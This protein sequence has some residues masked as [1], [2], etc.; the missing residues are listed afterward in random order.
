[1]LE[2]ARALM[3]GSHGAPQAT[4]AASQGLQ[5]TRDRAQARRGFVVTAVLGV[6]GERIRLPREI[7]DGE[8]DSSQLD[9]LDSIPTTAITMNAAPMASSAAAP[10]PFSVTKTAN[11]PAANTATPSAP[12]AARITGV[13]TDDLRSR[14]SA[15]VGVTP[16]YFHGSE[17]L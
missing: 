10:V 17:S 5:L 4:V 13:S 12:A 1:M 8:V 15:M 11:T 7:A 14:P 3:S 2:R 9:A 16:P 6:L